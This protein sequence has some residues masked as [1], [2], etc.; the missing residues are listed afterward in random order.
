MK[1][2]QSL[3]LAGV[4]TALFLTSA[5]AETKAPV[6]AVAA[7]PVQTP[8]TALEKYGE[9]C[10][11]K[12]DFGM[13]NFLV[14]WTSIV[15]TTPGM[16]AGKKDILPW[17]SGTGQGLVLGTVNT[18]GGFVNALTFPIAVKFPLPQGGVNVSKIN[19]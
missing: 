15:S 11:E 13:Q 16:P 9:R 19:G 10:K 12:L 6:S 17:V 5:F 14:G 4:L 2:F 8:P 7:E 18:V 1:Y 3:I